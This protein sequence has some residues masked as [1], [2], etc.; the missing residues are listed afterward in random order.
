MPCVNFVNCR[1][2]RQPELVRAHIISKTKHIYTERYDIIM[3]CICN[4]MIQLDIMWIDV[5]ASCFFDR[6]FKFSIRCD[7]Y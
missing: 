5:G 2:S 6:N 1:V 7:R 4:W 3:Y